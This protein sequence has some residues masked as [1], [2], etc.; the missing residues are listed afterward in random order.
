[1]FSSY[2]YIVCEPFRSSDFNS[3]TTMAAALAES[4]NP[5]ECVHHR[6]PCAVAQFL[7]MMNDNDYGENNFP[8]A[9]NRQR[10]LGN[11]EE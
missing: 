11:K 2:R 6:S 8:L 7:R 10:E 1:M 9:C 3:S 4:L 5:N